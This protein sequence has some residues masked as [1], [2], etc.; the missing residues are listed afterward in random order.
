MQKRAH[1]PI[2]TFAP[3][4][5]GHGRKMTFHKVSKKVLEWKIP[6]GESHWVSDIVESTGN[7]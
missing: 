1:R 4:F 7:S 2:A 5:S 6:L 3:N